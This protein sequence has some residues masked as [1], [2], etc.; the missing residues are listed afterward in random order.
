MTVTALLICHDGARWLP[1]VLAGLRDQQRRPDRILALDTTGTTGPDETGD[2][3]STGRLLVEALGADAVLTRP[4]TFPEAVAHALPT[5]ETDWVWLLHDDANPDPAALAEL[6]AVAES[7]GADV[8]GPKLREWPS[9][10][11]LLELGVTISGTGRRETGLERGEYDQG[12]HD[13]IRQVLAVNTAGMLVRREVLEHLGGFDAALPVFG[14]D[15]DF[16]WRAARAGYR[17]VVVPQAVVFHA[18]AAHRGLRRTRLTGR[19]TRTHR[20]EREAALY[21]L[22]ANVRGRALPFVAVRLVLGTLLRVLGYLLARSPGHAGDELAALLGLLGRPRR[23]ISARRARRA[24]DGTQAAD[25]RDVR[26]LLAPW[27]VPYRHGLDFVTD[28]ATAAGNQ[29]R[30][31]AERRRSARALDSGP[32]AD[33][34]D[35]LAADSGL[36]VRFVTSPVA[37]LSAVFVLLALWGARA[38]LGEVSGGALSPAPA[39]AADWWRL[40]TE[41]WH[42]LGQGTDAPEPGYLLPFALLGT[43]LLGSASAVVSVLFVAAVP[44]AAW[45]AWR[46]GLVVAE[47]GSGLPASRVLVGWA[48]LTYAA[49]P[50]ASGAWGQG[51]FGVVASAAVLPWLAHAALG[52]LEPSADRRWR[53]GWRCSLLLALVTAFTP[54]AWPFA[55]VVVAGVLGTGLVRARSAFGSRSVWGPLLVVV[56]VPPL[57][58]LPGT[59]GVLGH[60]LGALFLEAGRLVDTPGPTD[61]VAGRFGSPSAPAWAGLLLLAPA[62]GALLRRRARVAA[63]ACW[64]VVAVAAVLA[65]VLSRVSVPVPAGTVQPGLGFLLVLSQGALVVAALVAGQ[66]LW[67]RFAHADFGWRQPVAGLLAAA[68]L[69]VPVV[70]LGWWLA[71]DADELGP[72]TAS[73]VPAYMTQAAE[74]GPEHGVLILRGDVETGLT[75]TVRRDDGVTIGEDEI[76]ALTDPDPALDADVGALVSRPTLDVVERM[77]GHGLDYVVM[78]APADGRVAAT[79]DAASGMVQASAGD[80]STRAWQFE[81]DAA[82]AAVAGTGPWWHPWL[83]A[84]QVA[85]LIVTAVLCGPTRREGR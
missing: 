21:T 59:V 65:A 23:L 85:A 44:L 69:L 42:P 19:R 11:R 16:G 58:L 75:W 73:A 84:I 26:R 45:G 6:L 12:Q 79:L 56:A 82:P 2:S 8:L 81:Q 36:L 49:V 71:G 50:V 66:G 52:L 83:L 31:A 37:V 5:I 7:G 80:R 39:G 17:T 25:H 67:A 74:L 22:L 68:G 70:G 47:L 27:W 76:L 40:V 1:A 72:P 38:A 18:E 51:R 24:L 48:A 30:D 43:L 64:L 63:A 60:G 13:E 46:F 29:G 62:L 3:G 9:L 34:A 28:V 10:R 57:L 20:A 33:D 35:T 61:L 4:G 78:P 54:A 53:A 32:V 77:S 41:G 55:A 14:T 15:L